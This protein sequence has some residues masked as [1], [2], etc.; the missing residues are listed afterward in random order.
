MWSFFGI[1]HGKRPHD[2]ARVVLKRFIRKSQLDI[3]G[4]KLQNAEDVVTLLGTHLFSHLETFYTRERKLV[5]CV[6]WHVKTT[7]VDH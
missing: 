6:L 1:G 3:N 5:T 4:P 2:G 7:D